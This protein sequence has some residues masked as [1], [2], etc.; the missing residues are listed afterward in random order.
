MFLSLVQVMFSVYV[1]EATKIVSPFVAASIALWIV[2]SGEDYVPLFKSEPVF[3]T[4]QTGPPEKSK[5]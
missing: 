1:P 3:D 5:T 2:K 4:C